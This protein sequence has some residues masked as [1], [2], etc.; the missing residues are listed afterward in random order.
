[1]AQNI[2]DPVQD[3]KVAHSARSRILIDFDETLVHWGELDTLPAWKDGAVESLR[4]LINAEFEV[5]VFTSRA[6][7]RWWADH[8]LHTGED[9][10]KFG[11][12][13]VGIVMLSLESQGFKGLRITAEKEPALFYVDDRA[14]TFTSWPEVMGRILGIPR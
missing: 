6:S 12:Q 8:C 9:P 2:A 14:I 13:Q 5:V 4:A 10:E 11:A 1:M 3:V 7:R